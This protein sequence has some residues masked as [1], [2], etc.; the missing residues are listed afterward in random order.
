MTDCEA[1]ADS[2]TESKTDWTERRMALIDGSVLEGG[3]Q[4][5]RMAMSL[6]ALTSKPIR[7]INIRSGRQKP[8][9]KAQHLIGLHLIRDI[10]D[11][12]LTG[13]HMN[14]TTVSFK[15][16][17]LLSGHFF[18][19]TKTAGYSIHEIVFRFVFD[20]SGTESQKCHSY[21]ADVNSMSFVF[22]GSICSET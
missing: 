20:L 18:G 16:K 2:E 14:S 17:N 21:D 6:S 12:E 13:D 22:L 1:S 15:P 11:G 19:D 9:L 7:I 3:G 4:V 10:T 5:I 8:G